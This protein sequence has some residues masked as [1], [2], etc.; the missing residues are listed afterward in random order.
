MNGRDP[1]E[2]TLHANPYNEVL[3]EKIAEVVRRELTDERFVEKL[4][5]RIA[6]LIRKDN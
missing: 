3:H 1:A 2:D 4:A 5:K 6:T